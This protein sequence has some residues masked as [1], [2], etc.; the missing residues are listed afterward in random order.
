MVP[1][2][3]TR[4]TRS[5]HVLSAA[6]LAGA[7]LVAP[8]VAAAAAPGTVPTAFSQQATFTAPVLAGDPVIAESSPGDFYV[9]FREGISNM[10][11]SYQWMSG[12]QPIPGANGL[13]YEPTAA[14]L[15]AGLSVEI[16]GEIHRNGIDAPDAGQWTLSIPAGGSRADQTA[17]GGITPAVI[18]T[19]PTLSGTAGIGRSVTVDPQG[20]A[21]YSLSHEWL[22][23]GH[24]AGEA[25]SYTATE[26]CGAVSV[27]VRASSAYGSDQVTLAAEIAPTVKNSL[28]PSVTGGR[29]VGD[30]LTAHPGVWSAG[31]VLTYQ[32][33]RGGVEI[34]GATGSTYTQTAGD[35]GFFLGVRVTGTHGDD[36]PLTVEPAD[37]G[38]SATGALAPQLEKPPAPPRGDNLVLDHG[39]VNGGVQPPPAPVVDEL[40][41]KPGAKPVAVKPAVKQPEAKQEV[42]QEVK[43]QGVEKP[44]VLADGV[45]PVITTNALP[46]VD[47]SKPQ[48]QAA[49][50][51]APAAGALGSLTG[52][53]AAMASG[54]ARLRKQ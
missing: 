15:T 34:P 40:G 26:T 44:A 52:I 49:G 39:G 47:E 54:V 28:A 46:P 8:L 51:L 4:K 25:A 30:V 50:S 45:E 9:N 16:R 13:S 12:G 23:D 6:A 5:A 33:T 37:N 43:R 48:P 36:V 24:G 21:G 14:D 2:R 17:T 7:L 31:T 38:V 32:W 11:T 35:A 53:L 18:T 19:R 22:C 29:M 41:V 10:R 42:K 20:W 3:N 1:A 27:T